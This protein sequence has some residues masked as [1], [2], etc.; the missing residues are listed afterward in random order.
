MIQQLCESGAKIGQN[1]AYKLPLLEREI[2][3]NSPVPPEIQNSA[4]EILK[5]YADRSGPV[6]GI[7]SPKRKSRLN[8]LQDQSDASLRDAEDT[9]QA[10]A[11]PEDNGP[12]KRRRTNDTANDQE[13]DYDQRERQGRG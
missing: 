8:R 2:L 13:D 11:S 10:T 1:Q 7:R 9:M 4:I 12:N 3:R 5:S 6:C